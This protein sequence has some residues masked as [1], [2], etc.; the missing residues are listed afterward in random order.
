[1]WRK[2]EQNIAAV[3][4]SCN[5]VGVRRQCLLDRRSRESVDRATSE[6]CKAMLVCNRGCREAPFL[7]AKPHSAPT[8]A[9][10]RTFVRPVIARLREFSYLGIA[11]YP[12]AGRSGYY[13]APTSTRRH[14]DGE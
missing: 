11:A 3:R 5:A 7:R 14:C 9:P 8:A 12:V 13:R 10:D 2:A 6:N 4:L 1:M